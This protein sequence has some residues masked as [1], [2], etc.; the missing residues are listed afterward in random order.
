VV[1]D[2]INSIT[3]AHNDLSGAH[4]V[5]NSRINAAADVATQAEQRTNMHLSIFKSQLDDFETRLTD[6]GN[7]LSSV[8]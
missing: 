7:K 6:F 2:L 8:L 5:L 4:P 1:T 3:K